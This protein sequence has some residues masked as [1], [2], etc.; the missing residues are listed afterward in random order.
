MVQQ[1]LTIVKGSSSVVQAQPQIQPP[2]QE[3]QSK[4]IPEVKPVLETPVETVNT[5]VEEKDDSNIEFVEEDGNSGSINTE[6]F[7]KSTGK[8]G[9]LVIRKLSSDDS[10]DETTAAAKQESDE[11][12]D[13]KDD[14]NEKIKERRPSSSK[15]SKSSSTRSKSSS[16]KEKS[17]SKD[18]NRDKDKRSSS[19]SSL[20]KS[21]S[22]SSSSKSKD[23][24]RKD[25]ERSKERDKDRDKEKD[26]DR[27]RRN[28]EIKSSSSSSKSNRDKKDSKDKDKQK[29]DKALSKDKIKQD[30][31]DKEK[32]AEKDKDTLA[33]L[34]PPPIDKLGRIPKKNN[35]IISS[36]IPVEDK[37][38]NKEL[39]MKKKS[40]SVGIRKARDSEERPKT[41]KIFNSKMRSTGLEEEIKPAPSRVATGKKPIP[42]VQLP[43]IPQ[44]RPSPPKDIR[45]PIIPVEKKLKIDKIDVPERPGAIKL[46]PPKPKRKLM[47][48]LLIVFYFC[49]FDG[50]QKEGTKHLCRRTVF[51]FADCP[52][53]KWQNYGLYYFIK[54]LINI[55]IFLLQSTT[56]VQKYTRLSFHISVLPVCIF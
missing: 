42:S 1:W 24:D 25:K 21:S 4:V 16:S 8:S 33:K 10:K 35:S 31:N 18:E 13:E 40:F 6:T 17:R 53:R 34:I 54:L 46:I 29:S 14:E 5:N 15:G 39:E 48:I 22:S 43:T 9:K 32:Q 30:D 50:K 2:L 28:G 12:K 19:K 11:T 47:N 56:Y 37:E 20:S 44:K 51:S 23:R 45:E 55:L 49:R 26:K 38:K 7:Y 3:T 36:T 41:V 27:H 52:K